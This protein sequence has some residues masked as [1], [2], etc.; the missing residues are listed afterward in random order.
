[1]EKSK[2]ENIEVDIFLE[3]IFQKYGYDF[4]NYAKASIKRR[5]QNLQKK[6]DI[7]KISDIIPRMLQDR[8]F[9]NSIL[10]EFSITVTEMF[11][12]PDFYKSVRE[13]IV[14]YLDT[15]P[16]IKIWHA[17]C[18][19]G[20]EAYSLA[21]IL[22]EEK[23]YH[24]TTI[25]ATDFNNIALGKAKKGIYSLDEVKQFTQSYQNAGGKRSFSDYY[26]AK[27]NSAIIDNSLKANITFANHNLVTDGDFGEMHLI[28]C[29]NVLIYFNKV[30]QDR[31]LN[32][33]DSSLISKGFLAIGSKESLNFSSIEKKFKVIDR[34]NKIYRKI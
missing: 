20:E 23:L 2:R 25:F 24:K 14:P 28:F 26:H 1:M 5:I 3:A 7:K 15:Y 33:F 10:T 30:L 13:N 32:L 8:F 9:S 16:F 17:G 12:D 21:I 22:K 27:Y 29:R 18:A 34:K 11:R 19:T 31:V 4:R 6:F